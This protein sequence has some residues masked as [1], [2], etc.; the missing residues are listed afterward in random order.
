MS[1]NTDA[2]DSTDTETTDSSEALTQDE[3]DDI[4]WVAHSKDSDWEVGP[5]HDHLKAI[6]KAHEHHARTGEVTGTHH[7][8]I[9]QVDE[10]DI[11]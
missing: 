7:L 11:K 5:F 9:E 6:D 8:G 3:R 4:V 1:H 10:G 2:N